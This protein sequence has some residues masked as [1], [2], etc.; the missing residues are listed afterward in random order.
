MQELSFGL[1]THGYLTAWG[2]VNVD[3]P[4]ETQAV[5]VLWNTLDWSAPRHDRCSQLGACAGDFEIELV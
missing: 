4:V 3:T 1:P 5:V 2:H